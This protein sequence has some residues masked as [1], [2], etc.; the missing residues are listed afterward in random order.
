MMTAKDAAKLTGRSV[1]WLRERECQWCGQSLLNA[2]RYGCS[3]NYKD[4]N[5]AGKP[6]WWWIPPK[7]P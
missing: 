1:A 7:N 6:Q 2:I 3:D 5:P 4:C